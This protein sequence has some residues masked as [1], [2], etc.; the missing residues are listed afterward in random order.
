MF[1][2]RS[3]MGSHESITIEHALDVL[4]GMAETDAARPLNPCEKLAC[5]VLL[6]HVG[7][8]ALKLFCETF[9]SCNPLYR[10]SHLA[11]SL[12]AMERELAAAAH[13]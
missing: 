1:C 13:R 11:L 10:K 12:R 7:L 9:E 5:R 2:F 4:R 3:G 8:R 6:P